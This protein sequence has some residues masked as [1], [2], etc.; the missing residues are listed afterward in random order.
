MKLYKLTW[1]LEIEDQLKEILITDEHE[2][3][4][5]YYELRRALYYGCWLSLR[6]L[7]EDEE[8]VLREG[9]VLHYNDI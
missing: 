8:H 6:E 5:R 9:D 2:A 7:V 3:E 1:Y 4:V